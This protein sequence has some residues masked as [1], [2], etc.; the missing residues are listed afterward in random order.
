MVFL[1]SLTRATTRAELVADGIT[2]E[3]WQAIKAR[4]GGAD[5]GTPAEGQTSTSG[6]DDPRDTSP[7]ENGVSPR[8]RDRRTSEA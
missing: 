2:A 3:V 6:A 7:A 1:T 4:D 8:E 5:D